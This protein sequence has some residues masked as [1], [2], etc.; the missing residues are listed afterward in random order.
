MKGGWVYMMTNRPRGVLYIGVTSNLTRRI[1]EHR[2]GLGSQF[3]KRYKLRR[4]VYW[5]WHDTINTAIQREK[6]IKHWPRDWKVNLIKSINSD[7]QDLF[8]QINW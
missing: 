8:E 2:N 5:E 4:L 3:V 1:W 7:W 6:T